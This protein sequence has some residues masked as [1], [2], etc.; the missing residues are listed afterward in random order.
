MEMRRQGNNKDWINA[1]S[2]LTLSHTK[3]A[4]RLKVWTWIMRAV[5]TFTSASTGSWSRDSVANP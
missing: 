4:A 5:Q 2:R 3:S 1:I